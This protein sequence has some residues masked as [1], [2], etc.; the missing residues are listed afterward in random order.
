MSTNQAERR[1][2]HPNQIVDALAVRG[3]TGVVVSSATDRLIELDLV[4]GPSETGD[5]E[6]PARNDGGVDYREVEHVVGADIGVEVVV[7]GDAGRSHQVDGDEAVAA[8]AVLRDASGA[9]WGVGDKA[10]PRV[11]GDDVAG[12]QIRGALQV[13][14]V[15]V[16][17]PNRVLG[18]G[19]VTNIAVHANAPPI[20]LHEGVAADRDPLRLICEAALE[21]NTGVDAARFVRLDEVVGRGELDVHAMAGYAEQVAADSRVREVVG[22][23]TC[24]HNATGVKREVGGI[25]SSENRVLDRDRIDS[26]GKKPVEF[27]RLDLKSGDGNVADR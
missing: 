20:A 13:D 5:R 15:V 1:R 23:N 9:G 4:S 11:V 12:D 14:A 27:D 7:E 10:L 17:E 24:C 22:C 18:D 25:G 19:V 16:A 8:E 21:I 2:R 3:T 6:I 26:V